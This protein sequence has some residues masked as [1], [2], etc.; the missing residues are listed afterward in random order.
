[1]ATVSHHSDK[2]SNR[3]SVKD[4]AALRLLLSNLFIQ[5]LHKIVVLVL[6]CKSQEREVR[7][8]ARLPATQGHQFC[9]SIKYLFQLLGRQLLLIAGLPEVVVNYSQYDIDLV[10][11]IVS[12]Y[13]GER[14]SV[15][16]HVD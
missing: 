10:G 11:T 2:V 14:V 5:L 7:D 12:V 13:F 15:L 6:A 3:G 1:M 9:N 16:D 8:L 4:L